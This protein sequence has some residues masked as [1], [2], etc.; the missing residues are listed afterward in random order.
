M[1]TSLPGTELLI[2][3]REPTGAGA[4]GG[5]TPYKTLARRPRRHK[6]REERT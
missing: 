1:E 5:L 2:F 6:P 4:G 3:I